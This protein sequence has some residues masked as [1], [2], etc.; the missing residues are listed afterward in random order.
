M[1]QDQ[2]ACAEQKQ[3]NRI[4]VRADKEFGA[5]EVGMIVKG[6]GIGW[7]MTLKEACDLHEALHS[8]IVN[9]SD[10]SPLKDVNESLKTN[11]EKC[12]EHACEKETPTAEN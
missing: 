7:F 3:E 9:M 5:I 12:C 6:Q 8:A 10:T 2:G 1:T 4:F 11:A